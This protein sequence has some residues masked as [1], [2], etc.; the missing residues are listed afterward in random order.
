[1]MNPKL[2]YAIKQVA[3]LLEDAEELPR[4]IQILKALAS[5]QKVEG[6]TE[7]P[8]GSGKYSPIRIHQLDLDN[9]KLQAIYDEI[10]RL[11]NEQKNLK[12]KGLWNE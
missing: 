4:A 2:K 1:M 10:E 12:Y 9:L 5:G 11:K 6:T 3:P 7:K 8:I